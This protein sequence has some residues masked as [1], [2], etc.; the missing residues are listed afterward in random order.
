LSPFNHQ[1]ARRTAYGGQFDGSFMVSGD[2]TQV[3]VE[4]LTWF[5]GGAGN[6]F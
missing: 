1:T 2:K 6:G 5:F 4:R 3:N